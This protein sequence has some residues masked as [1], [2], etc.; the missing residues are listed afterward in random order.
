VAKRR[1][2]NNATMIKGAGPCEPLCRSISQIKERQR[3]MRILAERQ[4]VLD[5]R[6]YALR[7][8]SVNKGWIEKTRGAPILP[9]IL[10]GHTFRTG[11]P[12]RYLPQ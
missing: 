11:T 3:L 7:S 4:K 2:Y 9:S 5:L 6:E 8:Q 1:A 10:S 12:V